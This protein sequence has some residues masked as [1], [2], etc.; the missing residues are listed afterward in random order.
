MNICIIA[1]TSWYL[2]NFRK[3]TII[4]L[5]ASNYNVTLLCGDSTYKKKL[6]E[7]GAVV[8]VIPFSSNNVNIFTFILQLFNLFRYCTSFEIIFSF[9][10]KINF[11]MSI[12]CPLL[13]V[14]WLPNITGLGSFYSSSF[15]VSS[16]LR[17]SHYFTY[18]FAVRVFVQNDRDY[19]LFVNFSNSHLH[20]VEL[21]PGS[22]VSQSVYRFLKISGDEKF[23]LCYVSRLVPEKGIIILYE[24]LNYLKKRGHI[25]KVVVAGSI[26]AGRNNRAISRIISIGQE[27]NLFQYVGEVENSLQTL[28]DSRCAVFPS[29]YNEGTPKF[30]L[31]AAATGRVIITTDD[32]GCCRAVH[33][34]GGFII[35]K[36]SRAALISSLLEFKN[37]NLHDLQSMGL[38]N[39]HHIYENFTEEK[40]I[41]PYLNIVKKRKNNIFD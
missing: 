40:A 4:Q 35:T 15:I 32:P 33:P 11:M 22:G 2:Y 36:K 17:F 20:K 19:N 8:K 38:N 5:L 25:F 26:P 30:L 12:L 28:Y 37:Q 21:L 23:D 18:K 24:A 13:R 41:L 9:T 39:Y 34:N 16:L 1:N 14:K 6:E 27:L 3:S 7:L 10:T 29:F 31:E